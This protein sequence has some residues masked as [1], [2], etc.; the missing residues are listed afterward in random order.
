MILPHH[1]QKEPEEHRSRTTSL[2][3][4]SAYQRQGTKPDIFYR[5]GP[6]AG[7]A[8]AVVGGAAG[9]AAGRGLRNTG[10]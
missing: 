9:W 2:T 3:P 7:G 4:D 8:H 10:P 5:G 1:R 6:W